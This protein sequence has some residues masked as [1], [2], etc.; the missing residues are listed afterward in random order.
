MAEEVPDVAVGPVEDGIDAH[1]GGHPGG[2]GLET[3]LFAAIGIALARPEHEGERP[4]LGPIDDV[5]EAPGEADVAL[6]VLDEE[7]G[8]D[9][10]AGLVDEVADLVEIVGR[11]EVDQSRLEPRLVRLGPRRAQEVQDDHRVLPAVERGV[12]RV[13]AEYPQRVAQNLRRPRDALPQ[14]RVLTLPERR[15]QRLGVAPVRGRPLPPRLRRARRR[16]AQPALRRRLAVSHPQAAHLP[17]APPRALVHSR[18]QAPGL[19]HDQGQRHRETKPQES[20]AI[21]LGPT[22]DGI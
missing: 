5:G 21:A 22:P 9:V 4:G 7:V 20:H 13:R 2:G 14:R 17:A 1:E 8:G 11:V 10:G 19:E 18:D 6:D 3:L 16:R 15:R 12:H